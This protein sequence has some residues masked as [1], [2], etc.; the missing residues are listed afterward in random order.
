MSENTFNSLSDI[1]LA[2]WT[3]IVQ[4]ASPEELEDRNGRTKMTLEEGHASWGSRR[5]LNI[6]MNIGRNRWL[7]ANFFYIPC[8]GINYV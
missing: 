2:K 6:G 8:S 7:T 3:F 1:L 4:E 5:D